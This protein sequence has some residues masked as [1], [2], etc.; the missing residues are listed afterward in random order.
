MQDEVI[1]THC[2]HV[3]YGCKMCIGRY[4]GNSVGN[5]SVL[6][7]DQETFHIEQMKYTIPLS[8]SHGE[9][10]SCPFFFF[11]PCTSR[12]ERGGDQQE[13]GPPKPS[14]FS[15]P[16]QWS[17]EQNFYSDVGLSKDFFTQKCFHQ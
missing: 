16:V 6:K 11:L 17:I 8:A 3:S 12:A 1:C 14:K 4:V 13:S 5:I 2:F 10:S 7:H 15:L 9:S